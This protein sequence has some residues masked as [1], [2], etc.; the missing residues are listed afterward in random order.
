MAPKYQ[1]IL[2][3]IGGEALLG[4]R[5]YGI[6]PQACSNIAT[7]IKEV[8]DLGVQIGLVVGAGNIFRGIA[9][10]KNG[11]ERS[12]AD[13]MGM[14]ATVMNALALQD[15]LEK[16]GA[17]TRVQ[18]AIEMRAV[19]ETF[20]RR[21]A[22]R[23][24]EKGRIVILGA[25]TGN[26]YVTTDSGAALRALELNCDVLLKATK[27]DGVY[28]KDPIEFPDA[29]RFKYMSYVDAIKDPNVSV[30][31][32]AGISLCMDNHMPIYVFNLFEQGNLMRAV[33]GDDIGTLV[34]DKSESPE[35]Q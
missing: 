21:R 26:P 5:Q 20:I 11:I 33:M 10:S 29:N 6:S 9:A 31:D 3:K 16:L 2:L 30:M 1:R 34:S 35:N 18:S 17:Q 22:I 7:Q 12:T 8:H 4:D 15:A 14:L 13:Y 32:S 23:H 24:M 27:V 28:D 19:A 25:G